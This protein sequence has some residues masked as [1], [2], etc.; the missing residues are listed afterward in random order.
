MP[1]DG[2]AH[3]VSCC[4]KSAAW[5]STLHFDHHLHWLVAVHVIR[6]L[7]R[8]TLLLSR[9]LEFV[10][11]P[12]SAGTHFRLCVSNPASRDRLTLRS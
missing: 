12:S 5:G 1:S 7:T 2:S 9:S 11:T 3:L 6:T 4:W 8:M 10:D